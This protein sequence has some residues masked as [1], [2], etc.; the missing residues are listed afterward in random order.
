MALDPAVV[1]QVRGLTPD[2]WQQEFLTGQQRRILLGCTRG[3]GAAGA[4]QQE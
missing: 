4:G 2:R 1:L 3:A